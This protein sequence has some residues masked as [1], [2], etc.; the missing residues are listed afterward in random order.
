MVADMKVS[1]MYKRFHCSSVLLSFLHTYSLQLLHKWTLFWYDWQGLTDL[2]VAATS[3]M[4]FHSLCSFLPI[5][6]RFCDPNISCVPCG[7][8]CCGLFTNSAKKHHWC[9]HHTLA[10]YYLIL[11][12]LCPFPCLFM[13]VPVHTYYVVKGMYIYIYMP[14]ATIHFFN[15]LPVCRKIFFRKIQ[16]KYLRGVL[17]W[18]HMYSY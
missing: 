15:Q 18:L 17:T 13:V 6:E 16:L 1:A 8:L 7:T 4:S 14:C 5:L 12:L 3:F 9:L 11:L 2:S 10:R